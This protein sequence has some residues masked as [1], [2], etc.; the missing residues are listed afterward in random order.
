MEP[1]IFN[2]LSEGD[3]MILEREPLEQL[4]ADNQLNAYKH[5]G[6]WRAMDTLKDKNELCEIWNAPNFLEKAIYKDNKINENNKRRNKWG[7]F[8]RIFHLM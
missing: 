7:L 3:T 6:F 4:A 5:S 8:N 1:Q 2:Y